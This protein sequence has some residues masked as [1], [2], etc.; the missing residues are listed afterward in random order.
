[1][2]WVNIVIALVMAVVG[3]LLRPKQK[4]NNPEPS[5]VG[6][7]SFPTV[8]AS[9]VIPVFWG[10]CK[11]QGPNTTWF[12]DLEVVEI[13]KKVKTGWFSS[14]RIS[15]GFKYYLG[16]QFV[17]AYGEVDEFIDL[18]ADD[19]TLNP[20]NKTFSGGVC[21]FSFNEPTLLSSEEPP[22]GIVGSAR[23]YQGTFTQPVNA[24]LGGVWDEPDMSAFRPLCH[25]VLEKVYLGNSE[26]PPPIT[27]I[28]RRCPNPLG[29]T[30]GKHNING[31]AN[32]ACAVY[33]VMVNR[34]WG[35][36]IPAD[37]IDF[38][39][40]VECGN[41]LADEG[42]GISMNVQTAMLGKD[43]MA[44]MLRHADGIVYADPITGLYTMVLARE[45]YD[46]EDLIEVDA[47]NIVPETF[48]FS[49]TSWEMT[50]NTI[51]VQYTDRETFDTKPVQYQ[52]LANID[53]RGGTVDAEEINFLGFSNANAAMHAAARACKVKSSTLARAQFS[54]NRLGYRL[55]PGSVFKMSKPDRGISQLIMRVIEISYGTLDDP[56]I[57]IVAMEDIFA[58]NAVA[59]LNP[60][61]T[62]WVSPLAPPAAFT[63]QALFE[64]PFAFSGTNGAY[65]GTLASR[66]NGSDAGYDI[67]AGDLSGD[68]NLSFVRKSPGFTPS[69]TLVSNYLSTTDARD[70]VGFTINSAKSITGVESVSEDNF[71]AGD[72]IALI[73][74][75]AGDEY[76]A[77]KNFA[78]M[79]GGVYSVSDVLRGVYGTIPLTH[80]AG[81]T[82]WFL[83]YGFGVIEDAA[84]P[85]DSLARTIYSKL[86]PYNIKTTLPIASA[87]QL[88]ISVTGKAKIPYAPRYL[89][90]NASERPNPD[91]GLDAVV[92][93]EWRD[94]AVQ[95]GRVSLPGT[96]SDPVPAGVSFT[97]TLYVGGVLKR[98]VAG[99]TVPTYTYTV[100]QQTTDTYGDVEV[101]VKTV[102]DEDGTLYES[103]QALFDWPRD[104]MLIAE[105]DV[106]ILTED[107]QYILV[108]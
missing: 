85:P 101:R 81:A 77:F 7:F 66:E 97:L 54:M 89:R 27:L 96:G 53:V 20:S 8:D 60:S 63:R 32:I 17:F 24:Y 83:S 64:I 11:M 40:F 95:G 69:G 2:I 34:L 21:S 33:E 104:S 70:A 16:V 30:G 65:V 72:S 67:H 3:E 42:L 78:S 82:V 92:T 90:I 99:L 31:D 103:A 25:L 91:D 49:R 39:S 100:A 106:A 52:D 14:T 105:D 12:G 61:P 94:P 10:T 36:K 26:N 73:R 51:I 68:A 59:Y 5:A 62:E 18:L 55:R 13:T 93:W 45:D 38:D 57:K 29:L 107:N 84:Y 76:V 1:M 19:K 46:V 47:S 71:L 87:T 43:L 23:L 15:L 86:L 79:G 28:A 4:F 98:T 80:T 22:S 35:M 41:I 108:E 44:D 48:E 50:K 88:S 102:F 74:S 37:K 9:R 56:N 58:V 75:G 6:D